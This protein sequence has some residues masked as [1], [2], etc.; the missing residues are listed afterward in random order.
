MLTFVIA[1]A[2]AA[3][4]PVTAAECIYSGT[5]ATDRDR[6]GG[7]VLTMKAGSDARLLKTVDACARRY[8]WSV[9][10]TLN[11]NGYAMMRMG[12]GHL[13]RLL[14]QPKWATS[15]LTAVQALT[16]AQR[17][18]LGGTG[19]DTDNEVFKIVLARMLKPHPD[20]ADR[21][22]AASNEGLTRFVLLVKFIALAE[23]ERAKAIAS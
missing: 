9:D 23:L 12:A 8:R 16:P 6:I 22:K 20:L 13:A 18:R 15:A 10:R 5:P 17:E 7:L 3:A 19:S 21:L 1:M 11:A 14:G 4:T 2:G